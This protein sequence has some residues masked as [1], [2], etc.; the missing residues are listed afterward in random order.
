MTEI[1]E[2][3]EKWDKDPEWSEEEKK[4]AYNFRLDSHAKYCRAI[5]F[6]VGYKAGQASK[7]TPQPDTLVAP[8]S[9]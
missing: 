9:P 8:V 3:F 2:A 1:M 4:F 5:G 7:T 6:F